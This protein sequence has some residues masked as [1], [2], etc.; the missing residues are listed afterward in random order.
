MSV[1][2]HS[3]TAEAPRQRQSG[4]ALLAMAAALGLVLVLVLVGLAGNL[5]QRNEMDRRTAAALA[6]AKE[7]LI[8]YAA[9]YRD[10]FPGEVFGYLPC[11]DI[12]A[13]G[14]EGVHDTGDAGCT[15]RDVTVI[16]RLPWR[17]LGLPPLRDGDAEC[18][19]YA[20]SGN[21]KGN[22]N[23]TDLLN[24]DTNGLIEVM[25]PD[26][27]TFIA[28]GT[29]TLPDPS[30]RAAAVIFAPGAIL[31]GQNRA[32]DAGA[33]TCG[34]NYNAA[35]YLDTDVASSI[36]NASASPNRHTL[37]RLVA[38]FDSRHTSATNDSFNDKLLVVTP[39]EIFSTIV[40]R[41]DFLPHLT[42]PASGALRVLADC[43]S[44]YGRANSPSAKR[45]LPWAAVAALTEYQLAASYADSDNRYSGRLPYSVGNSLADSANTLP[46]S[47]V[48]LNQ[49]PGWAS[50]DEFWNNWKDHFFYAVAK[51]YS[52]TSTDSD[53]ADPCSAAGQECL[54]VDG[55]GRFAA[56]LIFAGERR[57]N[58]AQS[59]NTTAD[60]SYASADKGNSA[61]YLESANLAAIQN[62]APSGATP[63][64]FSRA[65]GNDVMICI[66]ADANLTV[67]PNCIDLVA[68]PPE[69]E[70]EA[71]GLLLLSYRDGSNPRINN[72]KN[73][74]G[75]G[76]RQEA[77][78]ACRDTKDRIKSNCKRKCGEAAEDFIK[79][80][81]IDN[82]NDNKCVSVM[83][84]LANCELK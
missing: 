6:Q 28:G 40:K 80:P 15:S 27:V 70:C 18:L 64:N 75:K 56:V 51:A 81:C 13:S 10:N 55:S 83:A 65:L 24:W 77:I 14:N 29:G 2:N 33:P 62:N 16:G 74:G 68:P 22:L 78:Q 3:A 19:W 34:G 69:N 12:V 21:F 46:V 84:E 79:K 5:D 20:V 26:G 71:D 36:A 63:R 37:T 30:R 76:P 59:R 43:I 1:R 42:D 9:K 73:F 8:G 82:L 50:V 4:A 11:P 25:A 66:Q 54:T 7:A 44:T 45:T 23:K 35:N 49:C 47:G 38:A 32:A 67:D 61:N 48:L 39:E 58:P 57:V 52:P 17:T 41:G 31:P 53:K 60:L 72:C